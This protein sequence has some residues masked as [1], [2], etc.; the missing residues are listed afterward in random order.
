MS[1]E[2]KRYYAHVQKPLLIEFSKSGASLIN[3]R[4]K[5]RKALRFS[6]VEKEDWNEVS[7]GTFEAI[8]RQNDYKF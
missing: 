3:T 8:L 1:S 4:E 2:Q 7:N 6:E 5:S